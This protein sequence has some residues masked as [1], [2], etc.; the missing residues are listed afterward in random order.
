[1]LACS[2]AD[3]DRT[4][5]TLVASLRKALPLLDEQSRKQLLAE[6]VPCNVDVSF[7]G[8]D[9]EGLRGPVAS[10]QVLFGDPDD[11]MLGYDRELLAPATPEAKRALA[12]LTAALDEVTEAVKLV[13]GDL[14]IVDN[15]RT[16]HARTPFTPRWDG[17]DRW[18][19][20]MYIRVPERMEGT[21]EAGD[22]VQF[23]PR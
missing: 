9:P 22:V 19:H 18:L 10:V 1:M 3:H 23:V 12:V 17:A 11:P 4:A 20:R 16:T 14:L 2:R 8:D 21:G 6:P 15:Y 13:P 7:R 5:E